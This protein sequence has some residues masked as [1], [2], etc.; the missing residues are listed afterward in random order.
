MVCC[1]TP[2][3]AATT[4]IAIS[5]IETPR[6]LIPEKAACPGVSKKTN[7]LSSFL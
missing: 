7:L 6:D 3:S 2:S 1:F 5:V 4:N